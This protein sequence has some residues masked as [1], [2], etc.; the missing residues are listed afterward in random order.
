MTDTF[1]TRDE[2]ATLTGRRRRALQIAALR[3]QGVPFLVDAMGWP[4]VVRAAVVGRASSP[5]PRPARP[6]WS[7][8]VLGR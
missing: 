4:V 5:A 8:A 3:E 2:V 6:A 7:P 1:L